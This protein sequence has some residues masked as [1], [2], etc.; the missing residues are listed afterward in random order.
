MQKLN[1][2]SISEGDSE[3]AVVFIHG[4]KGNK[5]SF[6]SLHS[7]LK[8]DSTT[9]YFP[10]APYILEDNNK[11]K[12]WAYEKEDGIFETKKSEL[13][14]N[15]FLLKNVLNKFLPENVFLLDSL[16][17]QQFVMNLY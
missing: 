14:L 17:A 8:L 1:F 6:T 12:S 11:F 10:E 4:W 13:L 9:W 2:I 15:D 7:M 5:N 16:K 3:K